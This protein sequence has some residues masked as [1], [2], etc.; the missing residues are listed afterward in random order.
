MVAHTRPAVCCPGIDSH[1]VIDWTNLPGRRVDPGYRKATSRHGRLRHHAPRRRPGRSRPPDAAA[2]QPRRRPISAYLARV[3]RD[4]YYL[5]VIVYD[6]VEYPAVPTISSRRNFARVGVV[7]DGRL[8]RAGE[9][10]RKHHHYLKST[11][12]CGR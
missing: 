11:V 2:D 1:L 10:Q 12:W 7:L 3:L 5:G 9:R 8:A 4:R 6:G